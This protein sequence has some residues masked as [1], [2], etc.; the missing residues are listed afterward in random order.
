MKY[1]CRVKEAPDS[2]TAIFDSLNGQQMQM[3]SDLVKE[4][5][6]KDRKERT[7]DRISC[8]NQSLLLIL[9]WYAEKSCSLMETQELDGKLHVILKN[10]VGFIVSDCKELQIAMQM[11]DYAVFG[12]DDGE[13]M[14]LLIYD[15]KA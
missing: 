10:K 5:K 6:E 11:A 14:L 3:V 4:L 13:L 7:E 12:E 8:V 9:K 15:Y 1:D 2:V